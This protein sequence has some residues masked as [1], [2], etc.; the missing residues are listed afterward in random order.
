V[1]IKKGKEEK[2]AEYMRGAEYVG[3]AECER[4]RI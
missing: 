2:D 1:R 3:S 4:C